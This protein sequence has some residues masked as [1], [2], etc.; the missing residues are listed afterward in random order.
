[1]PRIRTNSS[2]P[3]TRRRQ[4]LLLKS[5]TIDGKI[6]TAFDEA[7]LIVRNSKEYDNKQSLSYAQQF[8]Q[9]DNQELNNLFESTTIIPPIN[10]TNAILLS[11]DN[12][13]KYYAHIST[14]V[15]KFDDQNKTLSSS[16]VYHVELASSD[17][18]DEEY[19]SHFITC[20]NIKPNYKFSYRDHHRRRTSSLPSSTIIFELSIP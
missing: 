19:Q 11:N 12:E 5:S 16:T 17:D 20:L 4:L 14:I 13:V 8:I 6:K 1:M 9:S 7:K 15:E 10:S 18:D 2:T 3:E